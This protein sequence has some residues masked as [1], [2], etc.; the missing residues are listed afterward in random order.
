MSK[1][2]KSLEA[3]VEVLEHAGTKGAGTS[4]GIFSWT[5]FILALQKDGRRA[6]AEDLSSGAESETPLTTETPEHPVRTKFDRQLL[7]AWER[8]RR[9]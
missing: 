7:D 6:S 1:K 3:R 5:N 9:L 8:M 4:L 2:T